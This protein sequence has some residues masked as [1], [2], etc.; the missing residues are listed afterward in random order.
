VCLS[1]RPP[2]P[3]SS[4]WWSRQKFS[5]VSVL[6]HLLHKGT[7]ESPLRICAVSKLKILIR[8]SPSVFTVWRHCRE[9]FWEFVLFRSC[10]CQASILK[11]LLYSEV[12]IVNIL[13]HWRLRICAVSKLLLSLSVLSRVKTFFFLM[14]LLSRVSTCNFYLSEEDTCVY[15]EEDTWVPE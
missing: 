9:N 15:E 13:G 14:E 7:I 1:S 4:S 11:S 12:L 6:V 8:E 3:P 10:Y 5:K 2:C